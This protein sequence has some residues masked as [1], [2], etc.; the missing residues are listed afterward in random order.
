MQFPLA[1]KLGGGFLHR[2]R[3]LFQLDGAGVEEAGQLGLGPA[4]D[5]LDH[6]GFAG[7]EA[8]FDDPVALVPLADDQ[9]APLS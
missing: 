9:I 6:H 5:A 3:D 2:D 8:A 1:L 7:T 4:L